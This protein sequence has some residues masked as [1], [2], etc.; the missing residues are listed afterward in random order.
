MNNSSVGKVTDKYFSRLL[1]QAWVRTLLFGVPLRRQHTA[2][3]R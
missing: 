2:T 3:V 1:L